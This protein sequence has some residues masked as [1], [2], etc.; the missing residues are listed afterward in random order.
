V[1]FEFAVLMAIGGTCWLAPF[2]AGLNGMT[3]ETTL[4]NHLCTDLSDMGIFLQ[5]GLFAVDHLLYRNLVCGY[6][7][8]YIVS[9]SLQFDANQSLTIV[10]LHSM[11]SSL[12]VFFPQYVTVSSPDCKIASATILMNRYTMFRLFLLPVVRRIITIIG[13]PKQLADN[14]SRFRDRTFSPNASE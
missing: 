2:T 3:V 10:L 8:I 4:R 14:P 6:T 7:Q 12:M 13:K 11:M 9:S 5:K 1:R